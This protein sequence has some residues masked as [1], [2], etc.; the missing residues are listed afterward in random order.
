MA[1]LLEKRRGA[2]P[3]PRA[4][5]S[6]TSRTNRK[7]VSRQL[8]GGPPLGGSQAD[9]AHACPGGAALPRM[10]TPALPPPASAPAH[11]PRA[12]CCATRVPRLLPKPRRLGA[13]CPRPRPPRGAHGTALSAQPPGGGY[14]LRPRP[15]LGC[16]LPGRHG[17]AGA[18]PQPHD[19]LA[20]PRHG[21]RAASRRQNADDRAARAADMLPG[22]ARLQPQ[23][24]AGSRGGAPAG[25]PAGQA[26]RAKR[27]AAGLIPSQGGR[28]GEAGPRWQG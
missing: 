23:R 26:S 12:V 11:A 4:A 28:L 5:G 8:H 7:Q 19:A 24:R 20:S 25:A 18:G 2:R 3:A 21:R 17:G 13:D 22:P 6:S 16:P 15:G 9:E 10:P 1:F 14:A 27:E